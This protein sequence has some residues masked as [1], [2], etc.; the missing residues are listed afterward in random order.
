MEFKEDEE[1]KETTRTDP[2]EQRFRSSRGRH[3]VFISE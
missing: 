1:R 2:E 3:M